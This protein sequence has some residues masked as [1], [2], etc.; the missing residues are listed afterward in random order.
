[1]SEQKF[2]IKNTKEAI[3]LG[4]DFAV[5]LKQ[6]KENDGKIDIKDLPLLFGIAGS[7]GPGIDDIEKVYDELKDLDSDE[8]KELITYLENEL[9][10]KFTD[11]EIIVKI[12]AIL[13]WGMATA[14]LVKAF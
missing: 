7:I 11:K 12:K 5:I 10:G 13:E 2:G 4:A 9:E 3:K 1:M 8:A 6:A 14:N